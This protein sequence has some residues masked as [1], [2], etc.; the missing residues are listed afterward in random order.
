MLI[1]ISHVSDSTALQTLDL[2]RAPVIWSHSSAR[3]VW[4]VARNVPDFVLQR[5]GVNRGEGRGAV[6]GVVMVRFDG[7]VHL[8]GVFGD[9]ESGIC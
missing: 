9:V 2:T 7:F 8:W 4:D 3:G 1:D 6:D 5:L